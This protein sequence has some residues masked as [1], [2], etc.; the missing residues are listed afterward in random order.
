MGV[1]SVC[2]ASGGGRGDGGG[3]RGRK[4]T[5]SLQP[6]EAW[7]AAERGGAR[8]PEPPARGVP[9][10]TATGRVRRRG[11]CQRARAPAS[12]E[13][14]LPSPLDSRR[15]QWASF[16]LRDARMGA[17]GRRWAGGQQRQ[18]RGGDTGDYTLSGC[19]GRP[20]LLLSGR[21]EH[22][23]ARV[24]CSVRRAHARA[25]SFWSLACGASA[26]RVG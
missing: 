7:R 18:R 4:T 21:Q 13:Q 8:E 12:A 15:S 14:H 6:G 26:T 22:A 20:A 10:S 19:A 1:V 25:P 2:V 9:S 17:D 3:Q 16:G 5:D 11:Y 24:V 23:A